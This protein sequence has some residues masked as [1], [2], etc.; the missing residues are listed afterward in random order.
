MATNDAGHDV[1]VDAVSH[2]PVDPKTA[3]HR[4]FYNGKMYHF[5]DMVNKKTFDDDPQ[6]WIPTPHATETSAN[7]PAEDL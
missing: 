2:E 5:A 6:L 7:L 3:K 1:W 4:S